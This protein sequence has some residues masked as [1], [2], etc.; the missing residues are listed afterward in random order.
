M[1]PSVAYDLSGELGRTSKVRQHLRVTGMAQLRCIPH[2]GNFQL[3]LCGKEGA[4]GRCYL[5][6][7]RI[8]EQEE[9][10]KGVHLSYGR[11]S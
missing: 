2:A 10:D 7:H 3:R 4:G 11:R 1:S 6:I 8:L 5:Y 9:S